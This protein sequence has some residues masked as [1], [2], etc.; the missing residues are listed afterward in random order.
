MKAHYL[1]P[2]F[3]LF[4]LLFGCQFI[5]AQNVAINSTGSAPDV[6][7]MLDVQGA[8]KGLL[9][10]QISLTSLTDAVT[11]STPAHSLLVYNT[12]AAITGG[13]GYYFNSGTTALPVW[14]KLMVTGTEWKLGGNAGTTAGA[15]F[16]GTTDAQA[17][18]L[19]TNGSSRA[20]ISS[21]GITKIGDGINQASI[22]ADGTLTLEGDATVFV[23]LN[24]PVFSTSNSSSNPPSPAR[25]QRDVAG[26]SQGVFTYFFSAS[27][28]QE[29]YFTVQLPHEWKEGSTIFPH[30]HWVTTTD[31]NANKVRW[32]LEYTWINVAG[33]FGVTTTEYGE[34]PI[35]PNGTV[36]ALEHA[37]TPIG[38]GIAATGK[39]ISSYLVCRI[40]R[41]ATAT[42]DNFSGTAGL[43]GIDFHL[44]VD[45]LG[46]RTD[47]VK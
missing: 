5:S 29:L 10:P 31:V 25:L 8:N 47:F 34:D 7:A 24:V 16:I 23:D 28:E 22:A 21:A 36:S 4:L 17:L 12:N 19:K 33:N 1:T 45:A 13:K 9:I 40:F 39:T 20:N 44:E 14:N 37:I 43:L 38:S 3:I 46:S 35:A 11:V 18:V 6:S 2:T 30:V 42:T 26:T 15:D 32:G 41:D 27:S